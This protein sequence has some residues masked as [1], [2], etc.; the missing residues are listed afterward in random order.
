MSRRASTSCA[1]FCSGRVGISHS[2]KQPCRL[3]EV[4]PTGALP[5]IKDLEQDQYIVGADSIADYLEDKF[6][7][8]KEMGKAA[9]GKAAGLP[10]P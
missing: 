5:V 2:P 7:P 1:G 9:L 4:S 3:L 10:Q 8:G 6:G